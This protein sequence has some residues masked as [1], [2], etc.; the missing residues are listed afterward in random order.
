MG[1]SCVFCKII[2]GEEKGTIVF[3]DDISLAFL[4]IRP[5]LRG[6][7]LLVPKEHVNT[8]DDLPE[9]LLTPMMRNAQLLSKAVQ[10]GLGA[11]GSFTAIN[12]RISQSVPH[13]HIHIVPRWKGDGLFSPKIL[14]KR[15]PYRNN[16]E[17]EKTAEAIRQAVAK[18]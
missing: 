18:L 5:L 16:D 3:E 4:D 14:W 11:E 15:R 6:H 13:M 9:D 17:K 2:R 7:C 10:Q 12:T 8:L 1:K